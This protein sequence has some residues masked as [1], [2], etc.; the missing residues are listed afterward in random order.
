MCKMGYKYTYK[1]PFFEKVLVEEKRQDG[2]WIEAMG[3]NDPKRPDLVGYGLGLGE[4]SWYR[5]DSWEKQLIKKLPA[6]VGMHFAD[7]NQDGLTDIVICYQ[8]GKTME[9]CDPKG[10]KVIWLENPGKPRADWKEH[11]IGRTTAMHRL[12]VGHFTQDQKPEVLGLPIVGKPRDI[13]S[14]TPVVLFTAPEDLRNVPQWQVSVIEDQYYHVIHGVT[15]KKFLAKE[16][17]TLDSVL[18]AT[19]EG[20]SWLYYSPAGQRWH[21]QLIGIGEQNQVSVTGFKGSGDVDAGRIGTDS[22]AYIATIEPFHGNT[23]AVYCK[24]ANNTID[25]ISWRRYVLD[26]YGDPN[27]KGEGPGHF[28]IC[29]DFDG[30]GDE[31]FIVAMR[32]PLPWQGVFYYKA[33]DV[34]NGIF[35]GQSD[36]EV[37]KRKFSVQ[38]NLWFAPAHTNCFIHNQHNFMEI[39]TQVFGNGRMQKFHKQDYSTIYED[40]QMSPGYTTA[41]PFCNLDDDSKYIYPWHQYYA[42]N[43]CIWMAIE[44]H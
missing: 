19:E 7:I 25:R 35:T 26:V 33:I 10:G 22:F 34:K 37:E 36:Q 9:D 43:D 27:A 42:D 5:N 8:Y 1:I 15:V 16:G 14:T 17:I 13:H 6:P 31:E 2:Y 4:V 18:L 24:D 20:I 12:K 38:V 3:I 21:H 32:G 30:D 29:R 41:Q 23:V 44:Y 39:H 40:I 28:V 11:Y